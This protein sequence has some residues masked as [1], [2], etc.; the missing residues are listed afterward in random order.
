MRTDSNPA[1]QQGPIFSRRM[2]WAVVC[3]FALGVLATT[4]ST[5]HGAVFVSDARA[6]TEATDSGYFPAQFPTPS[7]PAESHIEA[8]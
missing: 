2:T 6:Q 8:F 1:E 4:I 7:G 5:G 3:G